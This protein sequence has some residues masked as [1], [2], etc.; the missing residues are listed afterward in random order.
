MLHCGTNDLK[1]TSTNPEKSTENIINLSKSMKADKNNVIISE[2]NPWNDQIN[3]KGKEVKEALMWEYN[4]RNIGI[5][6]HGNMNAQRHCNM[7]GLYR[8]WKG[9]NFLIKDI[10]F[11]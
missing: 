11:K 9:R 6:K 8:N 10:L 5:M 3:K 7:S 4:K 2:L 1:R